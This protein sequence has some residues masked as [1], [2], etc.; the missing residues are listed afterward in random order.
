[1]QRALLHQ[2]QVATRSAYTLGMWCVLLATDQC[3][4]GGS[5][6]GTLEAA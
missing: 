6:D 4:P 5:D 2:D 1:M 3:S